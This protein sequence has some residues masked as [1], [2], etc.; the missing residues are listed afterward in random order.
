[1]RARDAGC[2]SRDALRNAPISSWTSGVWRTIRAGGMGQETIAQP[3][4][5]ANLVSRCLEDRTVSRRR[6][7]DP[8]SEEPWEMA[9]L[10]LEG[11]ESARVP[12]ISG[13]DQATLPH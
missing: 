9:P 1:M 13:G 11:R 2:H 8:V 12:V 3:L 5:G 4:A 6:G 10:G 7:Q